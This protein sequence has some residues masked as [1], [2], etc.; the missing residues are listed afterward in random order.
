MIGIKNLKMRLIAVSGNGT[1][2]ADDALSV[3]S[4]LE[5]ECD[6]LKLKLDE[7]E[8]QKKDIYSPFLSDRADGVK[9]HYAIGR[10]TGEYFEYWN[11]VHHKWSAFSDKILTYDEAITLLKNSVIPT[12]PLQPIANNSEPV[13]ASEPY[14]W[15]FKFKNGNTSNIYET[16][17]QASDDYE[18]SEG[19]PVPLYAGPVKENEP[20]AQRI[21]EQDARDIFELYFK[22]VDTIGFCNLYNFNEWL[23]EEGRTL[24]DKLNED[25][26]PAASELELAG[27]IRV[28]QLDNV[29]FSQ[30]AY[31]PELKWESVYRF[32][33]YTNPACTVIAPDYVDDSICNRSVEIDTDLPIGTELY[34]RQVTPNKAEVPEYWPT[35]NMMVRGC[36]SFYDVMTKN[37]YS[38]GND[39]QDAKFQELVVETIFD[40]MLDAMLDAAP[41]ND[42]ANKAEVPAWQPIETAPKDGSF[43]LAMDHDGDVYKT[44]WTDDVYKF[45]GGSGGNEGWF[46][47]NYADL[48][49][50][51]PLMD[52]PT[53]WQPVPKP[54]PPLKDDKK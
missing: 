1:T 48:W 22:Y 42:S 25:R 54:L 44:Q 11:L 18:E 28:D 16:F 45:Q 51:S 53:H 35:P 8:N 36:E 17:E 9:G 15:T 20:V 39:E 3:I 12:K 27:F 23:N 34:F 19:E 52:Y 4:Q 46:S 29:V 40:A 14:R 50:D 47:G 13:Q 21:T 26:E 6:E 5:S 32:K 30:T 41:L 10:Y 49:G 43:I 7:M 24:L 37:G 2:L 38:L 31:D 33:E